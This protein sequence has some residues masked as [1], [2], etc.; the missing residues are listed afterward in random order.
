MI[1][2]AGE[3]ASMRETAEA[4]RSRTPRAVAPRNWPG[5]VERRAT[6]R[7]ALG[8]TLFTSFIEAESQWRR[9]EAEAVGT[10]FQ[11]YDWLAAWHASVGS[12]EGIAPAILMISLGGRPLMLA[13]FGIER[14]MGARC[15]V[16]LGGRFADYKGPL[17]AR[18]FAER[19]P[20]GRFAALWPSIVRALPKHDVLLLE[21]QPE[22]LGGLANPFVALGGELAPDAA[23]AFAL[24]STSEELLQIFRP[25]TRRNDRVKERKLAEKGEVVFRIAQTPTEARA[26]ARQILDA[27][28]AQLRQQGIA[29]IFEDEAHRAAYLELASLPR[30]DGLMHLQVAA[31]MLDGKMISGSIAHVWHDR[32][33]LMV[34]VYDPEHAKVSPGR[35]HLLRLMRAS[36]EAKHAV[37]DLSVGYAP[38]K[39]S[40]CDTP[41][42]LYALIEAATPWGLG[43]STLLNARRGVRRAIKTN[44]RLMGWLRSARARLAGK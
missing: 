38:Y 1:E 7:R 29:S 37:Y 25:E 12:A 41:M 24:P 4:P 28:V 14:R 42:P 33:T 35:L 13:P 3:R 9:F 19:L 6:A 27:K 36:I 39:E 15:L 2:T 21:N 22:R 17:L 43:I 20:A 18:D 5:R 30:E 23:Y 31:L 10:G 8:F 44:D 26:L 11:S 34:H 16:W 32:A 40:F